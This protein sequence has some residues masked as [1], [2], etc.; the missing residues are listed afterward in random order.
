MKAIAG[1]NAG[2]TIRT[3]QAGARGGYLGISAAG[4]DIMTLAGGR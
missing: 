4:K 3:S 1:A 2:V